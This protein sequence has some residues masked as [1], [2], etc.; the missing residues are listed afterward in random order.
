MWLITKS[1]YTF[2]TITSSH[3]KNTLSIM[4]S[5]CIM[6]SP[7][8]MLSPPCVILHSL[9]WKLHFFFIKE[10][11]WLYVQEIQFLFFIWQNN[12]RQKHWILGGDSW[13]V[14]KCVAG[15]FSSHTWSDTFVFLPCPLKFFMVKICMRFWLCFELLELAL[16]IVLIW[17]CNLSPQWKSQSLNWLNLLAL[18]I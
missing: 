16:E 17:F 2:F 11:Q 15:E 9:Y 13:I 5:P 14:L 6:L 8:I 18:F 3:W 4:L 12:W 7:H 1:E 10:K